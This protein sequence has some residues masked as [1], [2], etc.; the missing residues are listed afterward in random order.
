[1][2]ILNALD[3]VFRD[4]KSKENKMKMSSFN[5][6][7]SVLLVL[8]AGTMLVIAGCSSPTGSDTGGAASTITITG[9]GPA[10]ASD[11]NGEYTVHTITRWV[12]LANSIRY[13]FCLISEGGPDG[14]SLVS[15]E[16]D[17]EEKKWVLPAPALTTNVPDTQTTFPDTNLTQVPVGESVTYAGTV[18]TTGLSRPA[19]SQTDK[20]YAFE[21]EFNINGMLVEEADLFPCP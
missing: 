3:D 2:F 9:T 12:P 16:F 18:R 5:A 13:S 10:D 14:V 6:R 4:R 11:F 1:M 7:R 15:W 8:F 19:S 20:N 21:L 17:G